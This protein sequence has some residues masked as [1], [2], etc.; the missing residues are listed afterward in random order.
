MAAADDKTATATSS[1]QGILNELNAEGG[2]DSFTNPPRRVRCHSKEFDTDSFDLM[3]GARCSMQ[4][5]PLSATVDNVALS[6]VTHSDPSSLRTSRQPCSMVEGP[7]LLQWSS[8]EFD[9]KPK[10]KMLPLSKIRPTSKYDCEN[11][12]T[13]LD[14]CCAFAVCLIDVAVPTFLFLSL[15]LV[16]GTNLGKLQM[17][18]AE[19][20]IFDVGGRLQDLWE[21][22]YDD[23]DV[24]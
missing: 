3:D 8:E 6:S 12:Q 18:G 15:V 23:C 4:E 17:Y 11:V 22:Y 21:R 10:A 5:I 20:R 19:C 2:E 7:K 14:G 1:E 9:V 13:A 24:L 16:V